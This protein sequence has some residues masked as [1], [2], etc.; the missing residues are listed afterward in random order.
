MT[1]LKAQNLTAHELIGLKAKVA[2]TPDLTLRGLFGTVRDETRNTILVEAHGKLHRVPKSTTSFQFHLP[3][4]EEVTVN[5][6]D[7]ARRPEDRVKR[8]Q[9]W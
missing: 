2:S 8:R 9:R 5:G 6:S 1:P 7:L 3:N 4:D